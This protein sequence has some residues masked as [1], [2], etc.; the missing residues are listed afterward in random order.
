MGSAADRPGDAAAGGESPLPAA[1]AEETGA[2]LLARWL[3]PPPGERG[4]LHE[5]LSSLAVGY[6]VDTECLY[7]LVSLLVE[8]SVYISGCSVETSNIGDAVGLFAIESY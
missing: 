6:K 5:C 3:T 4:I 7:P 2:R 8:V 1:A